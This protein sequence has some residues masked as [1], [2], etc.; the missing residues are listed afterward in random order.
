MRPTANTCCSPWSQGHTKE[1]SSKVIIGA[2][3][4]DDKSSIR[5]KGSKSKEKKWRTKRKEKEN[6]TTSNDS[7]FRGNVHVE[8]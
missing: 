2:I 7:D 6:D 3:G 1:L 5:T 8:R 4:I